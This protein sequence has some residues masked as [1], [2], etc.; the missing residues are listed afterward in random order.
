MALVYASSNVYTE[1]RDLSQELAAVDNST[2]AIV[3]VGSRGRL[4]PQL[5][6]STQDWLTYNGKPDPTVSFAPY[7]ALRYLA[8]SPLYA[9]RAVGANYSF[10]GVFLQEKSPSP[11]GLVAATEADPRDGSVSWSTNGGATG[12][13]QNS[14]FFYADGPGSYSSSLSIEVKSNNLR[15]PSGLSAVDAAS[16]TLPT[17]ESATGILSAATYSYRVTALNKVGE[18]LACTAF[19]VTISGLNKAVYIPLPVVEGVAGYGIYGRTSGTE[20]LIAK[21]GLDKLYFIDRGTITPAGA[22][23][24]AQ[25]FTDEFTVNVYDSSVSNSRAVE[26]FE[27]S[28][29]TKLDGYGQQMELEARINGFSR[30]IR[31]RSNIASFLTTPTVY[32]VAKTAMGAGSSGDAVTSANIAS[33]WS[34]FADADRYDT[35]IFING[36]YANPTVQTAMIAVATGRGDAFCILDTPP[37]YQTAQGAADYRNIV[38]NSGSNRAALYAPDVVIN[39]EYTGKKLYLP[40]SGDVA[41]VFAFTDRTTYPWFAPA[42]PNRGA[43][44]VIGLRTRY[45]QAERDMLQ[46]SQVNY[47]FAAPGLGINVWEARTLQGTLS[48][49]SFI[50]VRRLVDNISLAARRGERAFLQEPNDEFTRVQVRA[51]LERYLDIVKQ[52]RGISAYQVVVTNKNNRPADTANGQ[53]VVDVIITPILPVEKIVV[54]LSV[55]RQGI[56]IEELVQNGALS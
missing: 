42:G 54:R 41:A 55:T 30:Y 13:Q 45:N 37:A 33:A 12:A 4:E 50:N 29:N 36:G 39:D 7:C 25:T 5:I 32:S 24:V 23:P 27:C 19:T 17:G 53:L 16:V 22:V 8:S 51:T 15:V 34:A 20:L 38:L 26:S 48:A 43:V 46:R 31:V 11:I 52:A 3:Y 47:I 2:A 40:P 9:V 35:R 49:F 28:L 44:N 56:S 14:A 21:V 18:S 10:G 1:E 6:T